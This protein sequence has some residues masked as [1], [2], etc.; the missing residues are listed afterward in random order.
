LGRK[1]A[2]ANT[3]AT[4]SLRRNLVKAVQ[5]PQFGSLLWPISIPALRA[6]RFGLFLHMLRQTPNHAGRGFSF[7][8]GVAFI[9]LALLV[10]GFS[11]IQ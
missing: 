2:N 9:A 7:W 11:V 5:R 3:S 1:P 6:E 8:I 4:I 10:I